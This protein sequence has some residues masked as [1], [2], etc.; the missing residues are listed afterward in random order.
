MEAWRHLRAII[1]LPGVVTLVIPGIDP[2]ADGD[3]LIRS[4]AVG[5]SIESHPT[6]HR[7]HLHLPGS[8]AH[9]R[10]DPPLRDG[11]QGHAR[12]V[13]AAAEARGHGASTA[14]SAIR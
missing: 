5:P 11:R 6:D 1:L 14:T 2:V 4:L 10:H 3:G 8:R 12:P 13:G 7:D 9:D